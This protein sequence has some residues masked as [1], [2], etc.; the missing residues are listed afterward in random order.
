MVR[1]FAIIEERVLPS[2][3]GREHAAVFR[4]F[5]FT[6]DCTPR[7]Q[8]LVVSKPE[9]QALGGENSGESHR[10]DD[11]NPEKGGESPLRHRLS[12]YSA[13]TLGP[14]AGRP[15]QNRHQR[16]VSC[17]RPER[18]ETYDR[19][20][21]PLCRAGEV[22]FPR[23][24][25]REDQ[26]KGQAEGN[27]AQGDTIASHAASFLEPSSRSLTQIAK[28]PPAHTAQTFLT[29]RPALKPSFILP[30]AQKSTVPDPTPVLGYKAARRVRAWSRW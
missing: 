24:V 22:K 3:L 30:R 4:Q 29:L 11:G 21:I 1:R 20:K 13:T 2:Q 23:L 18:I 15:E 17:S 10:T 14:P 25:R 7:A 26:P 12:G 19:A 5:V 6:D 28:A 8:V 27:A 16:K 9:I